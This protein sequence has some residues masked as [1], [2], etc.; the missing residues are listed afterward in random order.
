MSAEVS[1]HD[2]R[3]TGGPMH[4]HKQLSRWFLMG[5]IACEVGNLSTVV[6]HLTGHR[7]GNQYRLWHQA[8]HQQRSFVAT[9]AVLQTA[10]AKL[11]DLVLEW[12]AIP[13]KRQIRVSLTE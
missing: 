1:S 11:C 8:C 5:S 4:M 9:T 7:S 10:A 12:F 13:G 6:T 3:G 2:T